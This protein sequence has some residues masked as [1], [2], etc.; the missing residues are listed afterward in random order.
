MIKKNN[1][2]L[3]KHTTYGIGGSADLFFE[4]EKIEE[5]PTLITELEREHTPYI[6]IG[7]GSNLLFS[8]L[9][10]RGAAIKNSAKKIE[11]DGNL[12][13][14]ES[15]CSLSRLLNFAADSALSG[16][17]FLAGI[18]GSV[19][20]AVYGN[21]GAYGSGIADR[22]S[23]VTFFDG[24]QIQT[25]SSK[26]LSFSYRDSYFKSHIHPV[27]KVQFELTPDD[28]KVIHERMNSLISQRL[29]KHPDRR[30]GSCGCFFKNVYL[31]SGDTRRTGAGKL[32]QDSGAAGETQ[33]G[34]FVFEHHCNF[35]LNSGNATAQDVLSLAKRLQLAVKNKFGIELENEVQIIPERPPFKSLNISH[36]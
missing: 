5:L 35:I 12:I 21:A 31:N 25:K 16:L 7:G 8:D 27:M 24:I 28:P 9:G 26:E 36:C 20:G 3:S 33:G 13:I 30:L 19:G 23:N 1:E 18:P 15:G 6:I 2:L 22:I 29:E 10:I 4:I 34:A 11:L 17:E 32:L 14:V